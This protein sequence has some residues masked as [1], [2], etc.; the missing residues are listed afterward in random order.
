MASIAQSDGRIPRDGVFDSTFALK[1]DPYRFIGERCARL[2]SE[3]FETRL[4]LRRAYCMTGRDAAAVFYDRGLFQRAG[5]APM[6]LQA[7]LFGRAGVQGLDAEA[8]AHRKRIFLSSMTHERALLLGEISES[9]WHAAAGRWRGAGPVELYREARE[10]LCRSVCEWAG[11]PLREDEV[12]LRTLQLTMLFDSAGSIGPKH[13]GGRMARVG[14]EHWAGEVIQQAR[15]GQL[16][17]VEGSALHAVAFHRDLSAHPLDARVASVE[18]LNVLRPSVAVAVFAVFV[19]HA[20]QLHPEWRARI[21]EDG[22][23]Q[24]LHLFVQEVRRFYPFFPA[25]VALTCKPFE[26]R[27]MHFE[28]GVRTLLD[29]YGTDHDPRVWDAPDEFRPERIRDWMPSPYTLIPQGGGD[30]QRDH[31]CP[32]EGITI[33]LMKRAAWFLA[34]ARYEVPPQDLEIDMRRLPALPKSRFLLSM[35]G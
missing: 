24:S 15:R 33:E 12:R 23:G 2:G 34:R 18:L 1:L 22:S 25:V 5:A 21:V 17:P 13:W 32:G 27:G 19:A 14:A 31:R 9:H 16:K 10:V 26:W 35:R 30:T 6:R 4:L 11:V 28:A 20:L 7:T 8:H 29:L 3:V